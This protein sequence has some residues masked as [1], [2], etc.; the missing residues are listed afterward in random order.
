MTCDDNDNDFNAHSA[1]IKP[2]IVF[3]KYAEYKKLSIIF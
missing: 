1:I 2:N 3:Y